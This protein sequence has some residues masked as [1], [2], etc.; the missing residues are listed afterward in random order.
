MF[1]TY[2]AEQ[3][4]P[5][6]GITT[7]LRSWNPVWANLQYWADLVGQ[8]RRAARPMD[9]LRLFLARPGWLPE[10]LGG[11]QAPPEVD[12]ATGAAVHDPGPRGAAGLRVRPVRDRAGRSGIVFLFRQRSWPPA[13]RWTIGRVHRGRSR[14]LRRT[15]R[16]EA[17]GDPARDRPARGR[18]AARP[19]RRRPSR[20]LGAGRGHGDRGPRHDPH[21]CWRVAAGLRSRRGRPWTRRVVFGRA[22]GGLLAGL[23][24]RA[25][26][27]CRPSASPT[28]AS[29]CRPPP[30]R[31]CRG[32]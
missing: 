32:S 14:R 29:S 6:Y 21:G 18:G 17:M 2:V 27:T 11:F 12:P 22:L 19:R 26:P 7:P 4:E 9:K 8:A 23:L 13:T 28:C 20:V 25:A 30:W 16:A 15:A 3:E 1:G 10:D 24:D 31:R 5:V